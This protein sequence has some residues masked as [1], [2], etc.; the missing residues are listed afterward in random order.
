MRKINVVVPCKLVIT[1]YTMPNMT[2]GEL[3]QYILAIR[4]E[5]PMVL[6]PGFSKVFTEE[7]A[8]DLGIQGYVVTPISIHDLAQICRSVLGQGGK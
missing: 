2:G 4:P 6:C 7:K 5:M 1:D 8:R 3:A